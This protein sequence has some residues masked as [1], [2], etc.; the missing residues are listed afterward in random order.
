MPSAAEPA[1]PPIARPSPSLRTFFAPP[2]TT[3]LPSV[4]WPS[5]A[6]TTCEPRRTERIV[7]EWIFTP[8]V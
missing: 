5:P 6:T 1:N 8:F 7:V 4:T 2:L 3:V